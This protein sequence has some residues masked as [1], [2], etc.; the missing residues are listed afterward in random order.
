MHYS[1]TGG[2]HGNPSETYASFATSNGKRLKFEDIVEK[3]KL[4]ELER[5][6]IAHL[7]LARSIK[8]GSTLEESGLFVKGDELALPSSFALTRKGLVFAYD[9][10]EIACFAD[11]EK[12][13]DV[14]WLGNAPAKGAKMVLLTTGQRVNYSVKGNKVTVALPKGIAWPSANALAFRYNL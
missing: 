6:N 12:A 14:S 5:T 9:Y 13:P 7:K 3:G 8:D 10:Y 2:A 1:Y 11:G 4:P